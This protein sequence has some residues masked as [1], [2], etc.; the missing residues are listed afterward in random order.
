MRRQMVLTASGRDRVGIV[1][2]I[3]ALI[4]RFEGNI[5]ASRMVRLGGDFAMLMFVTAPEERIEGLR[6]AVAE[7]HY[8]KYDVQTRLSEVDEPE[9]AAAIP[10]AIN[11][12]G[13]DHMGILHQIA[14]Y[15]GQQGINVE[16][17]T[18]EIVAAPMSGTPL[19]TMAAVVRVPPQLAIEDLREAMEFIGEEVGVD[20]EVF[21]HIDQD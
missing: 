15:L 5:E 8:S 17:M 7:V 9:E 11:V 12:R 20:T 13:A 16:T 3:T 19:F 6:A 1:E 18:T 4:L 21:P 14:R 2:E 10:C